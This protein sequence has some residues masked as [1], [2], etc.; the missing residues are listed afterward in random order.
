[1]A[2][3]SSHSLAGL[4]AD[5]RPYLLFGVQGPLEQFRLP[6]IDS[7]LQLF[8]IPHSW[9]TSPDPLRP[10]TL[11]GLRN[12]DDARK[13]GSRLVSVKHVWEYWASADSY[14]QVHDVVQSQECRAKWEPYALDEKCTWKFTTAGHNRTLALPQQVARIN[15]FSYMAFLGP[16][17]LKHPDLEVGLFE[18]Y[19][20]N[21]EWGNKV[22]EA[23]RQLGDEQFEALHRDKGKEKLVESGLIDEEESLRAVWLGR[24]IC[25]TSRHLIDVFDLKKRAYIGTTSMESEASLLM[26]N[27][28]LAAPGKWI[29]DPFA[30][31]GSMLLT[32]SAFGACTFGSDIDGRQIRGKKTGIRHSAEQYG[33]WNRILDCYTFDMTQHPWRTG[34]LFDAIVTDPPYGVRAGA[35]RLGR[36]EGEREVQPQV[37]A[38]RES[39]GYHHQFHDYVPP[40]VGWPM[41]EVISTLITYAL[42]LL[43]PGGRLV[44]FLPTDSAVYEDIDIP[45]VPGLKTISNSPQQF[46]K[47]ARRLITMEK[48]T[49][50]EGEW[51]KALEGLDRGIR[52]QGAK[53]TWEKEQEAEREQEAQSRKPGHADFNV[54][55]QEGFRQVKDGIKDLLVDDRT[56]ESSSD[57][58]DTQ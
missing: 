25:D 26:A 32:A 34:E 52:R 20:E 44:F 49:E 11:I 38:G 47:W 46:G 18:E 21:K 9:P 57:P 22:R 53:S 6:E 23:R 45:V 24:K 27:Q 2:T 5:H 31:T 33:V 12:D 8:Q 48:T 10:Y 19:D 15:R 17:D 42:Y 51:R 58:N 50:T 4:A 29:Y 54:R 16:I 28:A 43:R 39:E 3:T 55:Y 41:E 36:D 14:H 30:G 35:K 13:L 1:M 37:I 56:A 7:V 40:S